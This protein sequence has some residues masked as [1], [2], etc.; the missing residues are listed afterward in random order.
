MN[1]SLKAVVATLTVITL[2]VFLA[3]ASSARPTWDRSPVHVTRQVTPIPKTVDLRVGQHPNYDR[4]VIDLRGPI[5][6]YDVRYV[7]RLQYEGSGE[8]VPL[9]GTR[10]IQIGVTTAVAHNGHGDSVYRGPELEQYAM[11]ALRGAAFTGDFEGT[12]SF[13]L[14]LSRFKSFRVFEL[15]GPNR[16]V[17]DL[18]H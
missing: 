7:K 11:P 12:V 13:G 14:A 2:G 10:F 9:K 16:L 8:T 1:R 15:T 18:H 5:P 3:P 6:G 4:V 17:I